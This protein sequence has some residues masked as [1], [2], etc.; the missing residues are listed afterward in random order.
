ML[1]IEKKI[2]GLFIAT[3]LLAGPL[4]GSIPAAFAGDDDD[5][6]EL[7]ELQEEC[8]EEPDNP[9]DIEPE[10]ELLNLILDLQAKDISLENN[11]NL[12]ITI[13]SAA[14]QQDDSVCDGIPDEAK[15]AD[16]TLFQLC[17]QADLWIDNYVALCNNVPKFEDAIGIVNTSVLAVLGAINTAFGGVNSVINT[18]KGFSTAFSLDIPDINLD[19]GSINLPLDIGNVSLGS[20]NVPL[21]IINFPGITPFSFLATIPAIPTNVI[22]NV[23]TTL[24]EVADCSIV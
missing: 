19:L 6:P 12:K 11:L 7:T 1:V 4:L 13:I 2:C 9:E 5:E 8:A 14:M 17:A 18:L 23:G 15:L 24:D 10:C 16:A 20:V 3:I 22:G 21:P